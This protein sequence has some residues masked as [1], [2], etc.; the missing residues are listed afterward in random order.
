[1]GKRKTIVCLETGE[2]FNS[3]ENAANAIGVSSG[4][5]SRQIKAGKPIKGFYYY[6]GEVIDTRPGDTRG[7]T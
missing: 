7:S 4:F 5:I 6:Y 2:Q 1:M 3:V